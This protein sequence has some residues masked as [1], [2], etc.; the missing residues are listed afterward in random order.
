LQGIIDVF[1]GMFKGM[2][3]D[4]FEMIVDTISKSGNVACEMFA[5]K[6]G[7]ILPHMNYDNV[8]QDR[9]K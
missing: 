3:P 7:S 1:H 8:P 9:V 2:N 5:A 4:Q 6:F